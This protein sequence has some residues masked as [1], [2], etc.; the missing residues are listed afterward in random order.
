MKRKKQKLRVLVFWCFGAILLSSCTFAE[1]VSQICY[2][3]QCFTIEIADEP[4]E[5]RQG[6]MFREK[7]FEDHGMLFVFEEESPH[8]FWMKNT[9]ISLD[10]IWLDK[11][12][13]VVHIEKSVPPC[14]QDLCPTY[15][16]PVLA[17]YVLELNA[18]ITSSIGLKV[19]D[20]FKWPMANDL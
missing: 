18:G 10:M 7:M 11:D 15:Q 3:K 12:M 2:E 1:N 13:K 17:R 4:E 16:S 19:G 14:K 8:S 9:L 6:L 5:Q 20:L